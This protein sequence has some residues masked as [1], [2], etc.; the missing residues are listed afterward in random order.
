MPETVLVL[1]LD[2]D[3]VGEDVAQGDDESVVE[4]DT[5]AERV[6]EKAGEA[7]RDTRGL[8]VDD[9]SD[10]GD[11]LGCIERVALLEG[12]TDRD[13]DGDPEGSADADAAV[14]CVAD[15]EA[16]VDGE[17]PD[18]GDLT[19][20]L[21]AVL[22]PAVLEDTEAEADADAAALADGIKDADGE[23]DTVRVMPVA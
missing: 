6:A 15:L 2:S 17:S 20:E 10:V 16:P 11:L 13:G 19:A 4:R 21:E 14:D 22:L 7:D 8:V 5:G 23:P 18:D 9:G 1:T 12:A 3:A